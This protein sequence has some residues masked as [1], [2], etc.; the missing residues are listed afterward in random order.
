VIATHSPIILAYPHSTMYMLTDD[1]IVE[2]TYKET[3]HYTITKEFLNRPE[4]MLSYLL[5]ENDEEC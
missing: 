3:E 1:G 5:A 4:K 2:T